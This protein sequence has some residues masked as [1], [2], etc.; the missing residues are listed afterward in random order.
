MLLVQSDLQLR[1]EALG[2]IIFSGVVV[3]GG[4]ILALKAV[5]G[6]TTDS[7]ASLYAKAMEIVT[8]DAPGPV[9][10]ICFHTYSGF[11]VAFT[12]TKHKVALPAQQAL[13][14][15]WSLHRYNL[16]RCLVP[17]PGTLFVPLLSYSEYLTQKRRVFDAIK[18]H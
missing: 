3:I 10:E 5:R 17:Y 12:Q 14:L 11:L 18:T 6:K 4:V 1:L 8:D 15:L 7:W 9:V 16:V 13:A 2:I